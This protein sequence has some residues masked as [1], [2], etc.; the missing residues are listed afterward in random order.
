M[1]RGNISLPAKLDEGSQCHVLGDQSILVYSHMRL[2]PTLPKGKSSNKLAL[3]FKIEK[4]T[5]TCWHIK[6]DTN[7]IYV[8]G[9]INLSATRLGPTLINQCVLRVANSGGGWVLVDPS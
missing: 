5:F 6:L 8:L 1:S 2:P 9:V 7:D 3:Q 4:Y